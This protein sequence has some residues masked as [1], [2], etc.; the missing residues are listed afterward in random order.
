MEPARIVVHYKDGRIV[1]GFSEDFN[2]NRPFF[3]L[4]ADVQKR[5]SDKQMKIQIED[6]KAVFFVE[7]FEGN[8]DY[9][10]RKEFVE[11]DKPSGR[12]VEVT[13]LDGEKMQGSTLGYSAER[14]GF[15]LFPSD[16]KGNNARVFVVSSALRDFRFL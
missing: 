7:T 12:K 16:P 10:E 2:V 15:F 14:S 8:P 1:K 11:E 3:R 5:A 13:F 6:L 4:Y 9:G